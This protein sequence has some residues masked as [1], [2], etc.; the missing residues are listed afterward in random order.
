MAEKD[1]KF[2]LIEQVIR[3]ADALERMS[4]PAP[5]PDNLEFANAYVWHAAMRRL[6][7]VHAINCVRLD[8]LRGIDQQRDSLLANSI[9]G[10]AFLNRSPKNPILFSPL[11]A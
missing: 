4:P 11:M 3:I 5:K 10:S 7:P 2:V 1:S 8:L 6:D 9:I